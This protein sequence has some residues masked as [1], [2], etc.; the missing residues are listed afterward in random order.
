MSQPRRKY[1]LDFVSEDQALKSFQTSQLRIFLLRCVTDV[2]G[3]F[4]S[5]TA[6]GWD[7]HPL[8]E[9]HFR[10]LSRFL[11]CFPVKPSYKKH[12]PR[13]ASCC[14][15]VGQKPLQSQCVCPQKDDLCPAEWLT[16]GKQSRPVAEGPGWP[17]CCCHKSGRGCCKDAGECR[18]YHR[19]AG[20]ETRSGLVPLRR[21]NKYTISQVVASWKHWKMIWTTQMKTVTSGASKVV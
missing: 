1:Y 16:L 17:H 8:S 2:C 13:I 4:V 6:G 18:H 11:A 5:V 15:L 9:D 3:Y 19:P 12:H 21:D 14:L 7:S 20:T 10:L